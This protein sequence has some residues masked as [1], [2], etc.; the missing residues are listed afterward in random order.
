MSRATIDEARSLIRKKKYSN[1]IVLLEGVR[2]LYRNSFDYYLE[3]PAFTLAIMEI[4][5]GILMK[6]GT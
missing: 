1:A 3:L 6:R 2:E 5:T 4:R